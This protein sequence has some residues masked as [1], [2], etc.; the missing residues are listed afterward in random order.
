MRLL[1]DLQKEAP[2]KGSIREQARRRYACQ[3]GRLRLIDAAGRCP[4]EDVG[5]P[6]GYAEFLDALADPDHE[7]HAEN[8]RW[9]GGHFD[10]RAVD[11][12]R[13]TRNLAALTKRWSRPPAANRKRST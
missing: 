4:P 2:E 10:P 1:L 5:G 13:L 11:L 3:T 6:P 12:E 7:Q 9:I 8:L